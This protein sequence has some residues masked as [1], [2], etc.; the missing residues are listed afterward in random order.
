MFGLVGITKMIVGVVGLFALGSVL[1]K[2]SAI[3]P[4]VW[5]TVGLLALI[6]IIKR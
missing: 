1:N 6:L 2:L 5:I 4:F 3:P